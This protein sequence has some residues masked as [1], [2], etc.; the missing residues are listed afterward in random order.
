MGR[1]RQKLQHILNFEG[2]HCSSS[3][4]GTSL[5]GRGRQ[6][7]QGLAEAGRVTIATKKPAGSSGAGGAGESRQRLMIMLQAPAGL[8]GQCRPLPTQRSSHCRVRN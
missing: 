5:A 7:R 2:G 1:Y 6:G 4:Q 8:A 3:I